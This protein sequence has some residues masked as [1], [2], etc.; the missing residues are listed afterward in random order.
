MK[1]GYGQFEVK[2]GC[3]QSTVK[4]SYGQA[5]R[6]MSKDEA[7]QTADGETQSGCG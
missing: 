4:D 7:D 6:F 5:P 3:G 2:D 1:D